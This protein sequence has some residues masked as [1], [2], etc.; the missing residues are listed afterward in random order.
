M[1]LFQLLDYAGVAYSPPPCTAA[2]RKQLDIIGFLFLASLTGIGGGT[3][4]D[5]VLGNTPVFWVTN[6][7]SHGVH[8]HGDGAL[9]RCAAG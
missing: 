5:L 3:I 7:S 4:R 1:S 8:R 6:C 9:F 2:S